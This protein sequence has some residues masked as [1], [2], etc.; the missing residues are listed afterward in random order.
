[1]FLV[2]SACRSIPSFFPIFTDILNIFTSALVVGIIFSHI[3][4]PPLVT[5]KHGFESGDLQGISRLFPD[6]K[7]LVNEKQI[8]D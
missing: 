6:T 1:V 3:N 2:N 8:I 7:A 4:V 5:S